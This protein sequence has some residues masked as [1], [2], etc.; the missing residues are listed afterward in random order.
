MKAITVRQPWASLIAA[1]YKRVETRSW[2]TGYRGPLAI[3][4]AKGLPTRTRMRTE[5]REFAEQERALGRLPRRI[6]FGAVVATVYLA[7]VMP[8]ESAISIVSGLE[9]YLGDFS[10]GR[11]AWFLEDARPLDDPAPIRGALGLWEWPSH[12]S[13]SGSMP[14]TA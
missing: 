8:T 13:V 1:G 6:P 9:R 10:P 7:R 11:F 2:A 12:L 14:A 4:A 3:H 5:E